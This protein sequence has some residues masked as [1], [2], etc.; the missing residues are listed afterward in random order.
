MISPVR[1]LPS[2]GMACINGVPPGWRLISQAPITPGAYFDYV[3]NATPPGT[4][5]YHSHLGAQRTDGLFGA[6][7]VREKSNYKSDVI[8]A[9]E[10]SVPYSDFTDSPERHTL[11]LLDWQR[12][13]SLDLFV[14]IHSALGFFPDKR[15]GDVPQDRDSLYQATR[16]PDG[17]EVGP[18]PYW[19]GLINGRGRRTE[20]TY[21]PLTVFPVAVNN[22]YRFRIIGAQ[23]VYAYSFSIDEL[24]V[25]ATDGHF[26][27][28]VTV[29]YIIVHSG[30]R[31]DFI[32]NTF[33][34]A[35]KNYW[36]RAV[37]LEVNTTQEHSA[38]AILKYGDGINAAVDWRSRY[39]TVST[40][41]HTC[42]SNNK[43]RVLNCPFER[44]LPS[45]NKMC[46]HLTSLTPLPRSSGST[47][48][49]FNRCNNSYQVLKLRV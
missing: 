17:T 47:E 32:L 14:R 44:Y 25:I 45:E 8:A 41:D 37:T 36:I 26:I 10:E 1:L 43:C 23:S 34:K 18:I 24:T 2:I 22:T 7:I 19:S 12:E 6:L 49:S 33:N 29:D 38:R 48:H 39:N 42:T 27:Q 46:I 13:A 16:G 30:E 31:Y 4:H 21:S 35:E 20:S 5:W 9:L 28:P 40:M 3:F 15:I 11:S